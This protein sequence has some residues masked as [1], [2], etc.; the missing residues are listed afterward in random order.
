MSLEVSLE[1]SLGFLVT[2]GVEVT[3]VSREE[4]RGRELLGARGQGWE[5]FYKVMSSK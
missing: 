2:S 1:V 5:R 4:E 3:R